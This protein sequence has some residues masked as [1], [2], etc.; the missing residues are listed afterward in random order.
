MTSEGTAVLFC[1]SESH[2]AILALPERLSLK[3]FI[4][5]KLTCNLG[6]KF[7][8]HCSKN[9]DIACVHMRLKENWYSVALNA[10]KKLHT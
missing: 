5:L 3:G 9:Y 8:F 2:S 4:F 1:T 10:N 6:C 7:A